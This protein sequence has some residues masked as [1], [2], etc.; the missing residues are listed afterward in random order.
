MSATTFIS[1]MG[2]ADCQTFATNVISDTIT[3]VNSEQDLLNAIETGSD[4]A[5][6]GQEAVTDTQAALKIAEDNLAN[7]GGDLASALNAKVTA[8]SAAVNFGVPIHILDSGSCYDYTS[9]PSIVTARSVCASA[10]EAHA[11]ANQAAAIAQTRADD[12]Q[13]AI[14]DAEEQAAQLQQECH[15]RV[16][17][18]QTESWVAAQGATSAHETEWKKAHEVLCALDETS[19]SCAVPSHPKVTKPQVADGVDEE[20]C[21]GT[22]YGGLAVQLMEDGRNTAR[23]TSSLQTQF[24]ALQSQSEGDKTDQVHSMLNMISTTI[25]KA[26]EDSA[27]LDQQVINQYSEKVN[28]L[29]RHTDEK[30]KPLRHRVKTLK[31]DIQ[32]H[33]EA[34]QKLHKLAASYSGNIVTYGQHVTQKV[35]TCCKAKAIQVSDV[36]Y[37]PPSVECDPAVHTGE[38]CVAN[39]EAELRNKLSSI[40][41]KQVELKAAVSSCASLKSSVRQEGFDLQQN[42][43]ECMFARGKVQGLVESISAHQDLI[44]TQWKALKSDYLIKRKAEMASYVKFKAVIQP[45]EAPRQQQWETVKQIE[46][47]I[48]RFQTLGSFADLEN[49]CSSAT[50]V[51]DSQVEVTYPTVTAKLAL[52][53]DQFQ[54]L[55]ETTS[56]EG[57]CDK[58]E[59]ADESDRQCVVPLERPVPTC[60]NH[61]LAVSRSPTAAPTLEIEDL[62]CYETTNA[63][64]LGW[65]NQGRA[66]TLEEARRVCAGFNYLSLECPKL[67]TSSVWCIDNMESLEAARKIDDGE[68]QGRPTDQAIHGGSNGQCDGKYTISMNNFELEDGAFAGG[69][70]RGEVFKV[71]SSKPLERKKTAPTPVETNEFVDEGDTQ[72]QVKMHFDSILIGTNLNTA[73]LCHIV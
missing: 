25:Q 24:A 36:V 28:S 69:W 49:E 6:E 2:K 26:I 60:E 51:D 57:A 23:L 22:T 54:A 67:G 52:K 13:T 20:D 66:S 64:A 73:T 21:T 55:T 63:V 37:T 58:T 9:H 31:Q 7:A 56:V 42:K 32:E 50:S 41:T 38:Q 35:D 16:R 30:A 18:Q 70:D 5:S 45:K 40:L 8:C 71:V 1:S 44:E 17:Y 15:C 3:S 10:K 43:A 34:G 72:T 12:A 68:C 46:C 65:V 62:G 11:S 14:T 19:D 53:L 29:D 39:A 4:C 48:K 59:T 47:L 27:A 33:T 61:I